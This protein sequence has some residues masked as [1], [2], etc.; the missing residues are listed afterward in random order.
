MQVEEERYRAA[1]GVMAELSEAMRQ[2]LRDG[3][4]FVL[5]TTPG[6]APP[7]AAGDAARAAFRERSIQFSALAPLAGVPQVRLAGWAGRLLGGQGGW[8]APAAAWSR[9]GWAAVALGL[10]GAALRVGAAALCSRP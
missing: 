1:Q 8:A 9:V 6:E 7:A 4:I 5:P 3:L 10:M 2:V